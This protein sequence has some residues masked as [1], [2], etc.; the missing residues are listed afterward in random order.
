MQNVSAFLYSL[1]ADPVLIVA[2]FVMML[3]DWSFGF[4]R[5]S[6]E[7]RQDSYTG[8]K[9]VVKKVLVLLLVMAVRVVEYPITLVEGVPLLPISGSA[10]IGLMVHEF[11]SLLKH[12]RA[13]GILPEW[14]TKLLDPIIDKVYRQSGIPIPSTA[15]DKAVSIPIPPDVLAA[16]EERIVGKLLDGLQGK[17]TT[18]PPSGQ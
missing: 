7:K 15:F 1:I 10:A 16:M 5:A 8:T 13:L 4:S 6:I 17:L 3:L 12:A 18:N 14:L 11:S 9:G 2:L